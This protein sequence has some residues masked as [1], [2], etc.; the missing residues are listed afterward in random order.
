MTTVDNDDR[1]SNNELLSDSA[2]IITVNGKEV[3]R[4]EGEA[5]LVD[6]VTVSSGRGEITAIGSAN[7]DTYLA[8]EVHER[9]YDAPETYL[10]MIEARKRRERQGQYDAENDTTREG[11]VR[12]DPETGEPMEEDK[13]QPDGTDEGGEPFTTPDEPTEQ[14][15]PRAATK[16]KGKA[17]VG[18]VEF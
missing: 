7:G 14:T 15:G 4:T 12:A 6:N 11:Y 3:W 16:G 5:M 2:Y 18:D 9:S 10:D 1:V 13:T 17:A 8:I